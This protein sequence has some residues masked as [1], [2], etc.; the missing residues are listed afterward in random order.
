[1]RL[2]SDSLAGAYRA[3]CEE[4]LQALKPGN[5]SVYSEGHDMTVADFRRSADVSAPYLADPGLALGEKIYY[6]VKFT[7]KAIGCNTNLGIVLL[8]APLIEAVQRRVSGHQSLRNSLG[9][10]LRRT[11]LEDAE[12][13]FKAIL[14]A[15]PGGLGSS[16][17]HDVR[18]APEV[19]LTDAMRA[20][21]HRDRIAYQYV[22]DY[23][24]IF[25]FGVMRYNRAIKRWGDEKWAAVSVFVGL[26]STMPDSHIERKFGNR[27]TSR[28]AAKMARIDFQLQRAARP[29][30]LRAQL[31]EADSEFKSAGINPGTT[32]D[33]TVA[34]SL[35]VRL[36][37][38][39]GVNA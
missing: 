7:Q 29:E 26:L 15:A 8:C 18:E 2:D 13:A 5:V 19:T 35:A 20:A 9:S 14:H 23:S 32:A 6:A 3:A 38:L 12:W 10:V 36:S 39:I 4:E 28:V 37:R 11:T 27:F 1:M 24:D 34:T 25:D 17:C 16:E 31:Q 33:L 21:S 30:A 22:S